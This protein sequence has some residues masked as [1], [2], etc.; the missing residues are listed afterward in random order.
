MNSLTFMVKDQKKAKFSFYRDRELWYVTECGFE[1]PVPI[2]D[3]GATLFKAEHKAVELMK[4]IRKQMEMIEAERL[5]NEN[6]KKVKY[7]GKEL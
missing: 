4:W 6:M 7:D 1:F 3:I 5:L 2:K